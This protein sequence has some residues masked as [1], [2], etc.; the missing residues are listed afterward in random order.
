MSPKGK[1]VGKK[2]IVL[3]WSIFYSNL[4]LEPG[5]SNWERKY[6]RVKGN[7]GKVSTSYSYS[8]GLEI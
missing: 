3:C 5:S 7:I 1:S 8:R 6:E 2:K 4:F